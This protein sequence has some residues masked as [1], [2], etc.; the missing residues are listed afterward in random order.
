[1]EHKMGYKLYRTYKT[2]RLHITD[3][4]MLKTQVKELYYVT[5]G[6]SP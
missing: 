3:V 2:S 1:M 6:Y 4:H 5:V